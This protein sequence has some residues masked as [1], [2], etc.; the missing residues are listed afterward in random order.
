MLTIDRELQAIINNVLV[1]AKDEITNNIMTEGLN[2]TGQ[3]I[4]SM[5]VVL[6]PGGG[7]LVGRPYFGTLETGRKPGKVPEDMVTRIKEW[8]IAKGIV[9]TRLEYKRAPS[10]NWQPKYTVEERSMDAFARAVSFS[11]QSKGTK[12]FQEGGSP[13]VY[14]T[15]I[16]NILEEAIDDI[17]FLV[18]NQMLK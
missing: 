15:V 8:A 16:D 7:A 14:T 4:S 12:L 17:M 9:P 13:V 18:T 6:R 3:T 10:E 1:R 5:A 11:I 2:A